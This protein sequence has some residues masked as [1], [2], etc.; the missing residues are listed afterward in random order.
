MG[1]GDGWKE[2]KGAVSMK[3]MEEEGRKE[4]GKGSV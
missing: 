1:K 3:C 2:E 4:G